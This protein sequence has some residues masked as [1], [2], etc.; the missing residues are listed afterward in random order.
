MPGVEE[1]HVCFSVS[2]D[3]LADVTADGGGQERRTGARSEVVSRAVSGEELSLARTTT[4]VFASSL[5]FHD[6]FCGPCAVGWAETLAKWN[7]SSAPLDLTGSLGAHKP[8]GSQSQDPVLL[9]SRFKGVG[10]VLFFFCNFFF[11]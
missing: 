7:V 1:G 2:K 8:P 4:L 11:F 10:S 5:S 3:C 6:S 9:T